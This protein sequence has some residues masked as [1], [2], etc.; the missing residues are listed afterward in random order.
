MGNKALSRSIVV[1]HPG[2]EMYGSDRVL[3]EDAKGLLRGGWNVTVAIPSEGPLA[4]LL[5]EH[6]ATVAICS[7][8]VLR[9]AI[10]TFSGAKIFISSLLRGFTQTRKL[11]RS[12]QPSAVLVNTTTIPLWIVYARLTGRRVAI[13]VHE[14]ESQAPK[15][16]RFGLSFPGAL[17][18]QIITN[19]KF[20]NDVYLEQ[21]PWARKN[22]KIIYNGIPGPPDPKPARKHLAGPVK[23]LYVGRIS[24]RKGLLILIE[25]VRLL[26]LRGLDIEVSLVGAVFSG[27]EHFEQEL[28]N[29]VSSLPHPDQVKFLGFQ[30]DVWRF[31]AQ[32]DLAVV[33]SIMEETFGNT[34]VESIL[35]Q[36]PVVSSNIGG[37]KEAV[38]SYPS[39]ILTD[40]GDAHQIAAGIERIVNNWDRFREAAIQDSRT[41][42]QRHDPQLFG[43]YI[44]ATLKSMMK[45]D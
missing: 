29:R 9:K 17:T 4:V 12:L 25:A 34:A 14:S 32:S 37:L 23:I 45:D 5:R 8:P 40:P 44:D 10:F 42:L 28:H 41:A 15:L 19:S 21:I 33:P 30:E 11:L 35:S 27:Y 16:I 20:T 2:S 6:G 22:S 1:A 18:D 26:Q 13:H 31:Y 36:R 7:T 39:A 38:D 43:E 3:L 24:E